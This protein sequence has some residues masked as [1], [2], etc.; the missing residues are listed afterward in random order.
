VKKI[1]IKSI[2]L[3][4]GPLLFLL[5]SRLES[6]DS[7]SP[8]AWNVLGVAAWV[9]CWWVTEA[10]P[11]AVAALLPIVLFPALGVFDMTE[12]TAPYA[13]PIIF[14][15]M[16]G[17]FIALGLEE[18]GLHK[19]LAL[20]LVKLT[21]TSA[22]GIILGFMLATGFLSMWISNTASTIMMLPIAIT[23][24]NLIKKTVDDKKGLDLFSLSLMLGIA[25]SANIGG[26]TTIIG[27]PPNIVFIGY[28]KQLMGI[29]IDFSKWML[30]GIPIGSILLMITFI[31]LTQV[32]YRNN[33]GRMTTASNLLN[34]EL[35]N[36]G[37]MG[38]EEKI[39]AFIFG[40]T[41]FMWIFKL[42]INTI[43]GKAILN[44]TATAMIGGILM[45]VVPRNF[46]KGY[47]LMK[48]EVTKRLPWGIL[49][50]FGGGMTLAKAMES[51]GLINV[52]ADL[53]SQHPMS[54]VF[55]YL[56]LIGSMLFL[57]ELMSNVALATLYLP[58]VIAIAEGLGMN[59]L[60]LSIPVA[61][62]ASCAF[63]MP[64]ST[65]PNAIVFSSGHIRM[66]QMI[67]TGFILNIIS[68]MILLFAAFSIIKW[69]FG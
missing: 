24:I 65:P 16:G 51:T 13:S 4:L 2:G 49:L 41:A 40:L 56:F 59:P 3:I 26:M 14:L 67:R 57:T 28:A 39:V 55:V 33:L 29:D 10:A 1:S 54:S 19:R 9:V 52:I 38:R 48:W 30:I 45:F 58:V 53:V 64:I 47:G 42:P 37:N 25:Y 17:F 36:L 50:L 5:I 7:L 69:V 27:T 34:S 15:F 44:D 35:K 8:E 31:F 61:M 12:A 62:A 18:H 23:V 11:M 60:L 68:V 43:L 6:L 32:L 21:G 20:N 63:M 46:R 22:N 66:N